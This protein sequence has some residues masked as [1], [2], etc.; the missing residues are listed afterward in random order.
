MFAGPEK[1]KIEDLYK[2]KGEIRYENYYFDEEMYS[3]FTQPWTL[4]LTAN[5]AYMKNTTS[6]FGTTVASVGVNGSIKLT[7]YWNITGNTYYDVVNQKLGLTRIGF[8]RDQRS[9]TIN[10]NW[11]PFGEY[12]VY[13]FLIGIKANILSDALK[14]KDRSFNQRNAPF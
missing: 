11:V 13:D 8:S 1:K 5:Y 2:T 3:R 6:M 10:F 9:F 4:N 14:Y 12:K 7:P